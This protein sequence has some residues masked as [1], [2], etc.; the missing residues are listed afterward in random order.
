[1]PAQ[2]API[3]QLLYSIPECR[4]ALGGIGTTTFYELVN[5]GEIQLIHIRGRRFITP[6]NCERVV[7]SRIKAA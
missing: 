6:E 7:A 4:A 5:A 1:M 2:T 3:K